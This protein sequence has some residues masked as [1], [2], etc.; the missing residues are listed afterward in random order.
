MRERGIIEY[1]GKE[2]GAKV[3]ESTIQNPFISY[4]EN[5]FAIKKETY[6]LMFLIKF[7]MFLLM[8]SVNQVVSNKYNLCAYLCTVKFKEFTWSY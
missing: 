4:P 1:Q 5:N 3:M 8:F 2:K 6:F 7:L